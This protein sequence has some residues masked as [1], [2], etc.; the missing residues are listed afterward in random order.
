ML[1]I[2]VD[3][4]ITK[5]GYMD[6]GGARIMNT[7]SKIICVFHLFGF[8]CYFASLLLFIIQCLFFLGGGGNN[9]IRISRDQ[10]GHAK[11]LNKF[12]VY[13]MIDDSS[14]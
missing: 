2:S 6:H 4:Y 5:S 3:F 8:N 9:F 13:C 1:I 11:Q 7:S 10:H 14:R 12:S